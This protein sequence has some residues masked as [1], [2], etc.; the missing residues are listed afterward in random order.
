MEHQKM[1]SDQYEVMKKQ[2]KSFLP[3]QEAQFYKWRELKNLVGK[4][5]YMYM[6]LNICVS[7]F[8]HPHVHVYTCVIQPLMHPIVFKMS[9]KVIITCI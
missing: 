3:E 6:Y 2:W 1:R 8:I 4:E 5:G 9:T 7:P